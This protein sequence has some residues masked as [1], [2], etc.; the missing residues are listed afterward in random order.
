MLNT[1]NRIR[2]KKGEDGFYRIV[3]PHSEEI[4][5]LKKK[6]TELKSQLN[7]DKISIAEK[8]SIINEIKKLTKLIQSL[9]GEHSS[10][11]RLSQKKMECKAGKDGG[12]DSRVL[13]FDQYVVK[14]LRNGDMVNKTNR[15]FYIKKYQILKILL[16]K[17][18]PKSYFVLGE[19]FEKNKGKVNTLITIQKRIHGENFQELYENNF[20]TP[21]LVDYFLEILNKNPINDLLNTIELLKDDNKHN[22]RKL[23][24][25]A[26]LVLANKDYCDAKNYFN[27]TKLLRN[28]EEEQD[29]LKLDIGG[30]SDLR[31][32][33]LSVSEEREALLNF[34]SP[35]VMLGAGDE[36]FFIDFDVGTWNEKLQDIYDAIF[37]V[38]K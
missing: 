17:Y 10:I 20:F 30:L 37:R 38:L 32:T 33:D 2:T 14:Y 13:I 27:R 8:E 19:R 7:K 4:D 35:N 29:V 34:K 1:I 23:L 25:L 6:V 36:I 15:D 26:K 12:K 11:I 21:E 9:K 5:N 18:I 16:G 22:K 3:E 28:I 31:I 24:I